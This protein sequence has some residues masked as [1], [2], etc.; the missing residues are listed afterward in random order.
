M[1]KQ[2]E[3]GLDR[4][5]ERAVADIVEGKWGCQMHKLNPHIYQI[6]YMGTTS[7][8]ELLFW[9]E[10]KYRNLD[11]DTAP[12]VMISLHK[13]MKGN[14]IA[15]ETGTKFVLFI[16]FKYNTVMY[17]ELKPCSEYRIDMGGR[18]LTTRDAGDIEPVLH[19]P[20]EQFKVL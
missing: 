19:I 15:R 2:Y 4:I 6:D 1:R 3:T 5:R 11:P 16:R 14:E 9:A 7:A 18:T 13:I 17:H 12:A 8:Q 10:V 20:M